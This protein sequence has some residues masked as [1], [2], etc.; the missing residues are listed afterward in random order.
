MAT[1]LHDWTIRFLMA[2][3]FLLSGATFVMVLTPGTWWPVLMQSPEDRLNHLE[4]ETLKLTEH[5]W[6]G[7]TETREAN[8]YETYGRLV[9]AA[10]R[11]NCTVVT[12]GTS[13]AAEVNPETR[14]IKINANLGHDAQIMSLAHELAHVL[15]PSAIDEDHRSEEEV[16]AEAVSYLVVSHERDETS[17]YAKY[18]V[19]HKHALHVLTVYRREIIFAANFIW[20]E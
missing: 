8:L 12:G 6:F 13:N 5:E 19:Q 1:R 14:F 11:L 2:V 20:G 7:G 10:R 18:L 9:L 3:T 16:F 4:T 15:E 17:S